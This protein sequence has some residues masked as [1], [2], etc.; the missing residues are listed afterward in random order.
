MPSHLSTPRKV[1]VVA[2]DYVHESLVPL[3]WV[4]ANR[5]VNEIAMSAAELVRFYCSPKAE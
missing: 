5:V 4:L 1:S 3:V 2:D